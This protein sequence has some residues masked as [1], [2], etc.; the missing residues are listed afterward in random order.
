MKNLFTPMYKKYGWQIP[1]NYED[2]LV[3]R[4]V[5]SLSCYFEV[6]GCKAQ[7]IKMFQDYLHKK[8]KFVL[9]FCI[10]NI[11]SFP[12]QYPSSFRILPDYRNILCMNAIGTD[13]IATW[14]AVYKLYKE[15]NVP[16]EK[17]DY[18]KCLGFTNNPERLN[19]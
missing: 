16:S 3:H 13:P 12:L 15:S 10:Y 18:L 5:I 1:S 9:M 2:K 14:D 4:L 8:T 7:A 6:E 17:L 11:S 19:R